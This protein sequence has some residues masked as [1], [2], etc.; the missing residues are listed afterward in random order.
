MVTDLPARTSLSLVT[1]DGDDHHG[2]HGD[3]VPDDDGNHLQCGEC[4][5]T[6]PVD[7]PT[8]AEPPWWVCSPCAVASLGGGSLQRRA[9]QF[10]GSTTL[11]TVFSA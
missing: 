11:R 3:S 8:D 9:V 6:F 2:G 7:D 5:F 10:G 4:G 1:A